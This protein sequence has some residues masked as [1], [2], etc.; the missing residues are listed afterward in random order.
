MAR[1]TVYIVQAYDVGKGNRLKAD[2]P[3]LCKSADAACRS[4][5][6]LAQTKAGV[7][8]LSSSGDQ[9]LGDYDDEPVILFKAGQLPNHFED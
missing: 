2:T 4:A 5:E 8:A 1:Q 9:E 3:I 7:I 6:R